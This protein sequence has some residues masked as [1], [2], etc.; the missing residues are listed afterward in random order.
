MALNSLSAGSWTAISTALTIGDSPSGLRES[1]RSVIGSPSSAEKK[2]KGSPASPRI[3]SDSRWQGWNWIHSQK[4]P[5]AETQVA[6]SCIR[7]WLIFLIDR[8][9]P[10]V[11]RW[12]VDF[13]KLILRL[14]LLWRDCLVRSF[15]SLISLGATALFLIIWSFFLSLTSTACLVYVLVSMGAAGVAIF[16][17]GYTSGL[18]I[19]VF[20]GILVIWKFSNFWTTGMLFIVGGYMVSRSYARVIVIVLAAY[21]LYCVHARAGWSGIFLALNLSFLSNDLL[22][23]LIQGYDCASE[24]SASEEQNASEP[25]VDDSSSHFGF[26]AQTTNG[27]NVASSKPYVKVSGTGVISDDK[28]N[29]Y[30]G[31]IAKIDSASIDEIKRIINCLDHYEAMGFIRTESIDAATLKKEY[32]KKTL[33]DLTKKK[34]YDEQLRKEKFGRVAQRTCS[35]SRQVEIPRAFVCAESKIFDVSEWAICQGVTC[36]PNTHKPTFHVNMV[37]LEKMEQRSDSSRYPWG[38]DAEMVQEDDEFE[39]WLQ[40]A[41]ASGLFSD[42]P[43]RRKSWSPFKIPQKGIRPWRKSP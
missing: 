16:F 26:F 32:Y 22:H 4:L 7:D 38:L 40:Q 29:V 25:V 19:I 6:L 24:G 37:G 31:K 5:F 21:A 8:H 41:L 23:K 2:K 14:L 27:D 11:V 12:C 36:K 39:L 30:S 10:L 34:S 35:A 9:G 33:S 42:S 3:I 28:F 43:K 20:F 15:R 1:T 13:G 18:L 17:L